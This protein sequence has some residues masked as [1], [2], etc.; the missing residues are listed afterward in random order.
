MIRALGIIGLGGGFLLVSP[1]LREDLGNAMAEGLE[2]LSASSPY[3]YAGVAV[4][5]LL[6]LTFLVRRVDAPR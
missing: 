1:S 6:A 4:F 5:T 3:S 2:Y